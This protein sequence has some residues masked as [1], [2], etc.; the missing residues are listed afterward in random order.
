M[1]DSVHQY[2]LFFPGLWQLL[3]GELYQEGNE[4]EKQAEGEIQKIRRNVF[5]LTT[6]FFIGSIWTVHVAITF[7]ILFPNANII[8]T[9]KSS[10]IAWNS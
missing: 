4:N 1:S 6:A 2:L 7:C 5:L 10:V 3:P 9:L 8:A